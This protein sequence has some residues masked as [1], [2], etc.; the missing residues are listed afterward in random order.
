MKIRKCTFPFKGNRNYVQGPD[1]FNEM[2]VGFPEN[3]P[4][5]IRFSA[6]GFLNVPSCSLFISSSKMEIDELEEINT[7]CQLSLGEE[8]LWMALAG[9]EEGGEVSRQD[10]DEAK[11]VSRCALD[12]KEV[13]LKG[14]SPYT[15]IETV[16]SMKKYLLQQLFP[17]EVGKWVFTRVDLPIFCSATADL[18]IVF[19]HNMNF[20]LLKSDILV[21]GEKVGDLYFSLVK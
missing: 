15:F 12:G 14:N 10:Y 7:R 6:H 9:G 18:R 13:W 1:L 2:M 3:K 17:D 8:T 5:K 4:S 11:V 19:R 16:V 21:E 20:R